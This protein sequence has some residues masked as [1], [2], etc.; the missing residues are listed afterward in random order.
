MHLLIRRGGLTVVLRAAAHWTS[1]CGWPVA[2]LRAAGRAEWPPAC[3]NQALGCGRL[4]DSHRS[5][6]EVAG[7]PVLGGARHRRWDNLVWNCL[8]KQS[9][10]GI[11]IVIVID[12]WSCNL[13]DEQHRCWFLNKFDQE[14]L[15]WLTSS[16]LI[17]SSN[18]LLLRKNSQPKLKWT[19]L[20]QSIRIYNVY[21][22]RLNDWFWYFSHRSHQFRFMH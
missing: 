20:L 18:F 11:S 22:S 21:N 5:G 1:H 4:G 19:R 8:C 3:H 6:F 2:A 10:S 13:K 7:Q 16:H 12:E 17:I 15:L 14:H 9:R